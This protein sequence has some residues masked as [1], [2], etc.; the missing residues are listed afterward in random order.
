MI[1]RL[2]AP[3]PA[4]PSTLAPLLLPPPSLQRVSAH[5][6]VAAGAHTHLQA[7]RAAIGQHASLD[8]AAPRWQVVNQHLRR[9]GKG[10]WATT[11]AG[12]G[13]GDVGQAGRQAAAEPPPP[14]RHSI[15]GPAAHDA[16]HTGPPHTRHTRL[17]HVPVVYQRLGAGDGGGGHVQHVRRGAGLGKQP[18]ALLHPK[19]AGRR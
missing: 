10:A 3:L 12:G 18:A 8:P 16:A 13:G 6:C 17:R 5:S 9:G 15:C 19:P 14:A 1:T 2:T 4:S 11:K 7:V